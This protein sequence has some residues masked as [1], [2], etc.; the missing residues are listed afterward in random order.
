M[1]TSLSK[2]ITILV[3]FIGVAGIAF[4]MS[5]VLA[6]KHERGIEQ[7]QAERPS[8]EESTPQPQQMP[9]IPA[10]NKNKNKTR[11]VKVR[12]K[13]RPISEYKANGANVLPN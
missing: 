1:K 7:P 2:A 13:Q 8:Q 6:P 12:Q 9:A 10:V 3:Y 5:H 4:F 11:R